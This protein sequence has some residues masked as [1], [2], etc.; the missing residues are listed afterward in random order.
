[1]D[2]SEIKQMFQKEG[3]NVQQVMFRSGDVRCAGDLYLPDDIQRAGS[4][5]GLVIG[6]SGGMV[7]E[8]LVV[9]ARYFVNAGYVVLAI[10]YRTFG[11]SEGEPRGQMFPEKQV[12]DFRSAIS[13]LQT[14]PE[15]DPDRIGLW[16]VS[17]GGCVAIQTAVFDRR[18]KC[19]VC[20]S[21]SIVN[22]WRYM[23]KSSGQEQFK[24]LMDA[25]EQDW[26]YRWETGEGAKV[27]L[28]NLQDDIASGYQAMAPE[29]FPTFR[30]ETLLESM[31]H[32]LQWVPEHFIEY[33]A[34]TPL[35]MVANGG[36]DP[37]HT[38]DE[39][40]IAYRKAGEPKRLEVL[41]Y[42][43]MGLYMG[44]GQAEAMHLAID[45]FDKYLRRGHLA[46]RSA[47]APSSIE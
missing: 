5:P 43:M 20:Q 18:V 19:V 39:V 42:D 24:G 15:V 14:R 30:N 11:A 2:K 41:P 7:K 33:L 38:L 44:Q 40:Q 16:G 13:Y 45:W 9:F 36:Y 35:L 25:L 37:Y 23:L 10:D 27:P 32:L 31:E 22:G 21:P 28:L 29:L 3:L 26:K 8:A 4:V 12:E 1:M 6:H 17:M 34:P 46:T 47:A